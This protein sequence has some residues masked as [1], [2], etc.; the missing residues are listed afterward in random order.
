M[1]WEYEPDYFPEEEGFDYEEPDPAV[2]QAERDLRRFFARRKMP[3]YLGQLEC[4]FEKSCFLC[5]IESQNVG[6]PSC[7]P[8]VD[9]GEGWQWRDRV[10]CAHAGKEKHFM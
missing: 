2:V 4:I 7:I 3:Y 8:N 6:L 10:K 9:N 1:E 5:S